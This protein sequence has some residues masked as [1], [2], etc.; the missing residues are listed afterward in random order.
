MVQGPDGNQQFFGFPQPFEFP[1]HTVIALN[2]TGTLCLDI[3][4]NDPEY[5]EPGPVNRLELLPIAPDRQ[6]DISVGQLHQSAQEILEKA[7][8]RL[9]LL[10]AP[11]KSRPDLPKFQY[12]PAVTRVVLGLGGLGRPSKLAPPPPP[13]PAMMAEESVAD[14]AD[15]SSEPN[16][17]TSNAPPKDESLADVAILNDDKKPAAQQVKDGVAP[18][19]LIHN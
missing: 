14:Q 19:P 18:K 8:K 3:Y 16:A 12:S 17:A 11:S 9:D 15:E 5:T 6:I 1:P 13:P 4:P 2:Y 7:M 10:E